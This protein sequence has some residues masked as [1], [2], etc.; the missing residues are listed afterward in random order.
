[1]LSFDC[2]VIQGHRGQEEQD[3]AYRTGRSQVKWPHGKHNASPSLAADVAPYPIDWRDIRRFDHFAGFV[4]GVAAE[5]GL[6]IRW[7]GDW[8]SDHDLKDQRFNDLVH[9]ELV[10]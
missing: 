9:F 5:M 4:K 10:L 7:G 1:M 6:T 3:Q 8:D 2:T